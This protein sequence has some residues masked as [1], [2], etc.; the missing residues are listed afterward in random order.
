[1]IKLVMFDWDGTIVDGLGLNYRIYSEIT[2][3]LD[4]KMSRSKEYPGI[5]TIKIKF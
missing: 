1:M 5:K 2:K 4:K 3:R